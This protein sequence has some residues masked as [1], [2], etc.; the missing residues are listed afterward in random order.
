[1]LTGRTAIVTGSS[2]GIGRT[3]ALAF[4]KAGANVALA[5]RTKSKL[6]GVAG[7][8]ISG[9]GKALVIPTDVTNSSEV[10]SMVKGT[11]DEFGRL[12][13]LVNNAG[14]GGMFHPLSATTESGWDR[15][16]KL[17]LTSVFLCCKA[18]AEIMVSQK[19]GTIVNIGSVAGLGSAAVIGGAAYGAAKAGIVNLTKTLA[20]ELG[21][22]NIRVNC[23]APGI[24]ENDLHARLR[25]KWQAEITRMEKTSPLGRFGRGEDVAYAALYLASE[26]SQFVTGAVLEVS[27][28]QRGFYD[29][30]PVQ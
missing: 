11:L 16:I 1:M 5:A 28:G 22:H 4:G 19:R 23:I 15:M 24:I 14:G 12:D 6:E 7:E 30:G 13:I 21:S 27:G 18:V 2:Q 25:E 3:I 26:A 10:A 17:N 20:V 9:G 8:I 29:P